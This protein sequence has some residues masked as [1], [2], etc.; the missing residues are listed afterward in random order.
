MRGYRGSVVETVEKDG[1]EK[2]VG[3]CDSIGPIKASLAYYTTP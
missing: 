2:T 3:E 1:C